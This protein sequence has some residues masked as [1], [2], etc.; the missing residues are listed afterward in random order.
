MGSG[1]DRPGWADEA[2]EKMSAAR[3]SVL[4]IQDLDPGY[5]EVKR[6]LQEG[7]GFS[8]ANSEIVMNSV[9]LRN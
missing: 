7:Y 1:R 8:E 6:V 5:N 9:T 4:A 3:R 2:G